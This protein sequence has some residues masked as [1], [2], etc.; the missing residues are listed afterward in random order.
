MRLDH[1]LIAILD[2]VEDFAVHNVLHH[3]VEGDELDGVPLPWRDHVMCG[4]LGAPPYKAGA[5]SKKHPVRSSW[6]HPL[7]RVDGKLQSF[8]REFNGKVIETE[9]QEGRDRVVVDIKGA[10]EV[11]SLDSLVRTMENDKSGAGVITLTDRFSACLLYTS[12]A[13][14]D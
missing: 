5:F 14:D 9:F 1:D 7:P 2:F 11:P 13:A 6:G 8:G 4:D 10:Y 3:A 12:D